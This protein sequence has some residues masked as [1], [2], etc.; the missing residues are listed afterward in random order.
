MKF[1][2]FI[3]ASF[4]ALAMFSCSK[5]VMDT[6]NELNLNPGEAQIVVNLSRGA[7]TT[8]STIAKEFAIDNGSARLFYLDGTEQ[9]LTNVQINNNTLTAIV[10]AGFTPGAAKLCVY[11]N[12][13]PKDG[14]TGTK[15]AMHQAATVETVIDR[16]LTNG[17]PAAAEVDVTLQEG[18]VTGSSINLKRAIARLG[19]K[20]GNSL[21]VKD[22]AVK[23]SGINTTSG[24]LYSSSAA[25]GNDG[26]VTHK[27][28][29]A[30]TT[31]T[32][33]TLTSGI[34]TVAYMYPSQTV[35]VTVTSPAGVEMSKTFAPRANM[36][37]TLKISPST[38][39][40]LSFSL[41]ID[42]WMAGSEVDVDFGSAAGKVNIN[43]NSIAG[44][45]GIVNVSGTNI[46]ISADGVGSRLDYLKLSNLFGEDGN[47]W[48][49]T[50]ISEN[51]LQTYSIDGYEVNS[52][53]QRLKVDV[54]PDAAT[55]FRLALMPNNTGQ[56]L[57]YF[58]TLG[59]GRGDGDDAETET[60]VMSLKQTSL[61]YPENF[62]VVFGGQEWMTIGTQSTGK[63]VDDVAIIDEIST[64]TTETTFEAKY[65]AYLG[66]IVQHNKAAG[67]LTKFA[68][69][70]GAA[71]SAPKP[72][73]PPGY[74][75][76]SI[77]LMN[78][79]LMGL[80][81]EPVYLNATYSVFPSVAHSQDYKPTQSKYTFNYNY[82]HNSG[83]TQGQGYV[84]ITDDK[85]AKIFLP[86]RGNMDGA[87]ALSNYRISGF[88]SSTKN[89]FAANSTMRYILGLDAARLIGTAELTSTI[90]NN[91][92]NSSLVRCVKATPELYWAK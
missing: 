78:T 45:V 25:S 65:Q 10:K 63:L 86:W 26:P 11:V 21:P 1:T 53:D 82:L 81:P 47:P 61:S 39:N 85:G 66:A 41:A 5:E 69:G 8:Y 84:T 20:S 89:P 42:A 70:T 50:A 35:T 71:A 76:P 56:D 77:S 83:A 40:S 44:V 28:T 64:R 32:D 9:E 55:G 54:D 34:E 6:P 91:A 67:A 19:A 51:G 37:Y 33:T 7:G 80:D 88:I 43:P 62:S 2:K 59:L 13:T 27:L 22:Y 79:S 23:L 31:A 46:E 60:V 18:L 75:I 29:L 92:V 15:F 38:D 30:G 14:A 12:G 36:N 17:A 3:A 49:I 24:L 90:D 4:A 52:D 58:I 68:T 16:D 87:G 48:E 72:T 74:L 73:C 57:H